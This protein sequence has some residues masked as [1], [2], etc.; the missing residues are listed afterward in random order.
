MEE[1]E[2]KRAVKICFV[3]MI[4]SPILAASCFILLLKLPKDSEMIP[5]LICGILSFIVS[6]FA[7]GAAAHK[8]ADNVNGAKWEKVIHFF[9]YLPYGIIVVI[10]F[11]P[12]ILFIVAKHSVKSQG[13]VTTNND[14]ED[15]KITIF[16]EGREKNLIFFER[17]LYYN[18]Y[19]GNDCSHPYYGQPYLRYVE[20]SDGGWTIGYWLSFNGGKTFVKEDEFNPYTYK[21]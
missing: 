19:K 10:F 2:R 15:K 7:T 5:P 6:T 4:I 3:I 1:Q 21:N 18:A 12:F 9:T 20:R 17:G 13:T 8:Y 14:D 11:I 16:Y